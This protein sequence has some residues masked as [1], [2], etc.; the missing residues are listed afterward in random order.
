MQK[1]SKGTAKYQSRTLK[2]P[3]GDEHESGLFDVS[4]QD[5][6]GKS[7]EKHVENWFLHESP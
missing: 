5:P 2:I 6:L 4:Y 1:T 3:G 7:K